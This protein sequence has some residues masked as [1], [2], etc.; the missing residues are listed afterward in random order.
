MRESFGVNFRFSSCKI[1]SI[2][3][4]LMSMCLMV[5]LRK[6]KNF[7]EKRARSL[8]KLFQ[9]LLNWFPEKTATV[10]ILLQQIL[11][12]WGLREY[13]RFSCRGPR[14]DGL[15]VKAPEKVTSG[16]KEKFSAAP[17]ATKAKKNAL[18]VRNKQVPAR[19][20]RKKLTPLW[21]SVRRARAR[22]RLQLEMKPGLTSE[23]TK[24]INTIYMVTVEKIKVKV[25]F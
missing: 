9:T 12:T 6:M 23:D 1:I 22:T 3:K 17:A 20:R 11:L 18:E 15:S 10:L 8:H 24:E 14:I 2:N 5:D 7:E 21:F 16:K 13:W 25:A 19:S 4:L